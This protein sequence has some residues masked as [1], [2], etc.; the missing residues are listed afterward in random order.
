MFLL[1][2]EF[3]FREILDTLQSGISDFPEKSTY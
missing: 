3:A 1:I 2:A